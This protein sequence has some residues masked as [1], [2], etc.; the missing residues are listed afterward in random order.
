MNSVKNKS[1]LENAPTGLVSDALSSIAAHYEIDTDAVRD[2]LLD[3]GAELI[4][5]YIPAE[6]LKL[7][8]YTYV[9][10]S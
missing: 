10:A 7:E 5:E 6:R 1:F 9:S 8:V 4:Y 3:D 2:E